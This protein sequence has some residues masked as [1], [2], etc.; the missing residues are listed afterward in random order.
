MCVWCLCVSVF[1]SG[2]PSTP[3]VFSDSAALTI[4]C[5]GV[6][7]ICN[8]K[9]ADPSVSGSVRWH[10]ERCFVLIAQKGGP[11][12]SLCGP[13][14]PLSTRSG[15]SEL[16]SD[17]LLAFQRGPCDRAGQSQGFLLSAS[18]LG[19]LRMATAASTGGAGGGIQNAGEYR[20]MLNKLHSQM[21]LIKNGTGRESEG[22]K[23]RERAHTVFCH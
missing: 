5:D 1:Q 19:G 16:R 23:G 20:P 15:V 3:F 11:S 21:C 6:S 2:I 13:T 9:S 12:W 17:K 10:T 14:R 8:S 22:K 4:D 18:R 7:D